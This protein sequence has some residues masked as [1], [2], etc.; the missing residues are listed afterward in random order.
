[1]SS[2]DPD[3]AALFVFY[4]FP[5]PPAEPHS[6]VYSSKMPKGWDWVGAGSTSGFGEP[7]KAYARE[8]QFMGPK[9]SKAAMREFL[10]ETF[11]RLKKKKWVARF[12]IRQSYKP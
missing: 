7:P 1:M 4:S 5:P 10:Q 8:E 11:E 12:K 3:R 2:E 6:W 9:E